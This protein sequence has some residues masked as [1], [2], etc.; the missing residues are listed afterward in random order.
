MKRKPTILDE[1]IAQ[2]SLRLPGEK[3]A[4][5]QHKLE[6]Q[7]DT[8]HAPPYFYAALRRGR[9]SAVPAIIAEVKK[10]SPSRG[11]IREDFPVEDLALGLERG[12]ADALSVL[13]ERDYFF[14]DPAY[15]RSAVSVV[16]IPVLRKDFMVDEY[17]I[18]QARAWGAS[19]ILLIAAALDERTFS[20]LHE[21]AAAL[22]LD[23]L[24]EIHN[25]EELR[26]VMDCGARIIGVNSR[27]LRTFTIDLNLAKDLLGMIPDDYVRVAESGIKTR[28]D[29]AMLRDAGADAFLIGETLM[30]GDEP[31]AALRTLRK[32]ITNGEPVCP[33][34]A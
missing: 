2:V 10:G 23:V 4:V 31:E 7:I 20:L 13:T 28:G 15:L 8:M 26:M 9:N 16:D 27:D 5:P 22:G 17:Q 11:I 14:G 21:Q 30:R 34:V 1:I 32:G 12:G 6:E 3:V 25:T 33:I 19:A 18:Y 29:M 24:A